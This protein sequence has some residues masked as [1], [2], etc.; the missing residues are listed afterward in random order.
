MGAED[1]ISFLETMTTQS[2]WKSQECGA[3]MQRKD[4]FHKQ[5]VHELG[6]FGLDVQYIDHQKFDNTIY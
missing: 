3:F 4:A 2:D 6:F 1:L 5:P